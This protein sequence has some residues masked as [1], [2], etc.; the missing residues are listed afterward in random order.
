MLAAWQTN[1][2]PSVRG[3]SDRFGRLRS[4]CRLGLTQA[5]DN[6]DEQAVLTLPSAANARRTAK[7]RA[8]LLAGVAVLSLAVAFGVV[9]AIL[10]IKRDAPTGTGNCSGGGKAN[11]RGQTGTCDTCAEARAASGDGG[12]AVGDGAGQG[13]RA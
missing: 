2:T 3:P 9:F 6:F 7:W 13:T 5:A 8:L 12:C 4:C 1:L 11:D 10:T